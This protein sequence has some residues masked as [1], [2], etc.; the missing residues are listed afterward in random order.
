MVTFFFVLSG[1]V[2][3][4]AYGRY[5]KIHVKK[6]LIKRIIKIYPL[7]V[8]SLL[9][10]V[11]I[12]IMKEKM[13]YLNLIINLSLIQSWIPPYPLTMNGPAWYLS[14]LMFCY[15]TFPIVIGLTK[16][17]VN[18]SMF[19]YITLS[20]WFLTQVMLV[21]MLNS[22]FYQGFPSVSHDL[23][24]Y[25]PLS[26][27]CSFLLGVSGALLLDHNSKRIKFYG[28]GYKAFFIILLFIIIV[29][30]SQDYVN[31]TL[32]VRLPYGSSFYAPLFL[33]L[34]CTI[35]LV[36]DK[37]KAESIS[38]ELITSLGVVSY[39]IYILQEPVSSLV[40]FILEKYP[41]NELLDL[42]IYLTLLFI[43]GAVSIRYF[44]KPLQKT[45]ESKLLSRIA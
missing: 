4:V 29:I 40:F 18:L 5:E 33:L 1:F 7:Y 25:F 13:D 16:K 31:E 6:F 36:G 28:K 43:S 39:P 15:I 30:Q 9:L 12:L 35:F 10:P 17:I 21:V 37:W 41:T 34:I 19:Y 44:D 22:N 42:A 38:M 20:F 11:S 2:L 23:I 26:H 27:Y 8:I 32:N 3:V 14:D 24:F 45:M